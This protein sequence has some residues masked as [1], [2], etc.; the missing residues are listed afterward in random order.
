MEVAFNYHNDISPTP[1][2]FILSQRWDSTSAFAKP[3]LR[4][5]VAKQDC[6][7]SR[8]TPVKDLWNEI[9]NSIDSE[10]YYFTCNG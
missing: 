8:L 5:E 2:L 1:L 4:G 9:T 10:L 3:K 7:D 6:R